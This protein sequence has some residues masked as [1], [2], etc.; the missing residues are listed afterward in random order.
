[1]ET[2]SPLSAIYVSAA[3]AASH[4]QPPAQ[5]QDLEGTAAIKRVQP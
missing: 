2:L 3:D 1:M 5:L 4:E